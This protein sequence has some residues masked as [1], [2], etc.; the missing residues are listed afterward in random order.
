MIN[1]EYPAFLCK[2]KK[3]DSAVHKTTISTVIVNK[4]LNVTTLGN[5]R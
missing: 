3:E 2:I 4:L 5:I 1:E